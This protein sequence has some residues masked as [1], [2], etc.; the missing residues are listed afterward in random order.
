MKPAHHLR[1]VHDEPALDAPMPA[2]VVEAAP[3][4]Y[5][6]QPVELRARK[7]GWTA[8]RQR[9]FLT[10]LAD[11]GSIAQA[12]RAAAITPRSAWRLRNHPKGAAFGRAMDAAQMT[13]AKRLLGVAFDRA[14]TGT[15]RQVWRQGQIVAV[16]SP[17]SDR[18]LMFLL[19]HLAPDLFAAH[20]DVA[21]GTKRIEAMQ[22]G[23][24][25]ALAALTD[26]V[27]ED[28]QLDRKTY[29]SPPLLEQI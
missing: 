26:T 12:A 17:P 4:F 13:A 21:Q 14:T 18:L 16:S 22:A 19:R 11:T 23:F 25:D 1:P 7:D 27:I 20:G 3:A 9:T 5:A 24:P 28:D 6:Y 2:A 10:T 8:E 29:P 15:S